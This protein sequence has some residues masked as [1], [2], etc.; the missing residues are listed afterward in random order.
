LSNRL[1]VGIP[2]RLLRHGDKESILQL[3]AEHILL[4]ETVVELVCKMFVGE[5]RRKYDDLGLCTVI[6][7]I[8]MT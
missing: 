4:P 1:T 7:K 6:V 5:S 8:V 2:R 3:A